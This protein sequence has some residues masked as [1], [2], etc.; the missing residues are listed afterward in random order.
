MVPM[1]ELLSTQDNEMIVA[2]QEVLQTKVVKRGGQQ[3]SQVLNKWQ[4]SSPKDAI[5]MVSNH[6][7]S[8]S[9]E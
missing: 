2:P 6:G 5:H 9:D 8:C 7:P 4:N 3:V 1:V